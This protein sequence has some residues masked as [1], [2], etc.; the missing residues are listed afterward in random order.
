M[1]SAFLVTSV[2]HPQPQTAPASVSSASAETQAQYAVGIKL[3]E[4]GL[5]YI[6]D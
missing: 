4:I 6:I 3:L 1:I 2:L 5:V